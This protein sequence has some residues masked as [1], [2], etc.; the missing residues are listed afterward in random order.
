[1][2]Q[3]EC[4]VGEEVLWTD[5]GGGVEVIRVNLRVGVGGGDGSQA[6]GQL[7]EDIQVGRLSSLGDPGGGGLAGGRGG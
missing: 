4:E 7:L 5:V 3:V 1:M 2:S 6:G